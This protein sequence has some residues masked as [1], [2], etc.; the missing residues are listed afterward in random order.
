LKTSFPLI[1]P[2]AT[3]P[4]K[5]VIMRDS[6][7][8]S[9]LQQLQ[10]IERDF[11]CLDLSVMPWNEAQIN[12]LDALKG[13][14][15]RLRSMLNRVTVTEETVSVALR[16]EIH[17]QLAVVNGFAQLLQNKQ[18]GDIG[19]GTMKLLQNILNAGYTMEDAL[20]ADHRLV[21]MGA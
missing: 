14:I 15:H 12:G 17:C 7:K 9:L 13:S 2:R 8:R 20:K 5:D 1:G 21:A 10:V 19:L 3:F 4:D 16:Q 18:T 6:L 11:R